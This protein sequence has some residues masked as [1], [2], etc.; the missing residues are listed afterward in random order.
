MA[1]SYNANLHKYSGKADLVPQF[2]PENS[3]ISAIT[4]L[5]KIEHSGLINSWIDK[6]KSF[7]MQ[8]PVLS[9]DCLLSS[10]QIQMP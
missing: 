7:C 5:H 1:L 6:T 4:W 2:D 9:I 10:N 8:F 3:E